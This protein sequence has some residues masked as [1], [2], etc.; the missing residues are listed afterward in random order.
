[1]QRHTHITYM[2]IYTCVCI[3]ICKHVYMYACRHAWACLSM[4]VHKYT[5]Y[6]HPYACVYICMHAYPH[7][8][9]CECVINIAGLSKIHSNLTV[10]EIY[11]AMLTS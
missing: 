8:Y 7:T 3:Y 10:N 5:Y 9:M 1:M 4:Y 6:R 11:R 2:C